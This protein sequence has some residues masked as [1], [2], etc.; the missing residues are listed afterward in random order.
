[1]IE[2]TLSELLLDKVFIRNILYAIRDTF[3]KTKEKK[4][5]IKDNEEIKQ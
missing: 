3:D 5:Y 1:M 2:K 4:K